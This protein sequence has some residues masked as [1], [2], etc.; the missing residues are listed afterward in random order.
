MN[1]ELQADQDAALRVDCPPREQLGC[2]EPA[3]QLCRNLS[4]GE[5][6]RHLPAHAARLRAAGVRHAPL[7]P[8]ELAA[9]PHRPTPTQRSTS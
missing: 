9:D 5:H 4:T 6:L 1:L 2:G 3:G 8:R 7:D